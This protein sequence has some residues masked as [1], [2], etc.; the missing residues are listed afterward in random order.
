[1]YFGT[2][3]ARTGVGAA[4]QEQGCGKQQPAGML[5]QS[6]NLQIGTHQH[7]F[8]CFL[9]TEELAPKDMDGTLF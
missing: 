2:K 6:V 3:A 7:T 8:Q 5:A 1:M 9:K 4:P